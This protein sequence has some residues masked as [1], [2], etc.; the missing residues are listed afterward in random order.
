MSKYPCQVVPAHKRKG[1]VWCRN[2]RYCGIPESG[3]FDEGQPGYCMKNPPTWGHAPNQRGLRTIM[4]TPY[5]G[6]P[7]CHHDDGCFSGKSFTK[8][9]LTAHRLMGDKDA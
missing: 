8:A 5:P 4:T 2:C 1:F 7:V 9:E 6:F 3:V